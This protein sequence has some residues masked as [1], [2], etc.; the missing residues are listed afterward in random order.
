MDAA[1]T[2]ARLSEEL[3][4]LL[5]D[6]DFAG[7][8]E[9]LSSHLGAHPQWAAFIHFQL[10]RLYRRWNKLTSAM[11]HLHHAMDAAFKNELFLVQVLEELNSVRR[12]QKEQRP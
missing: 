10:G 6:E 7:A 12:E 1:F 4:Q 3:A 8:E 5:E 2:L 11:N 9:F